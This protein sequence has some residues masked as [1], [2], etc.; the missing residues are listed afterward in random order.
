M[1]ETQKWRSFNEIAGKQM[2]LSVWLIANGRTAASKSSGCCPASEA[3]KCVE[4]I[5]LIYLDGR[6]NT[7]FL[8][9]LPNYPPAKIWH[10]TTI[11]VRVIFV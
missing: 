8:G 4:L 11:W 9:I 5:D 3:A 10:L 1:L 6:V 7:R 2:L